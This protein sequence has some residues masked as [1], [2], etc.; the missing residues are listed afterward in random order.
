[1]KVGYNFTS[2]E[3][4]KFTEIL[5]KDGFIDYVE[6]LIDNFLSFHP[7]ELK[8]C[9]IPIA[10]HIMNSKF[11]ERSHADLCEIADKIRFVTSY[12]EILY[13]SDHILEFSDNGFNL[14]YLQEI[15]YESAIEN[16]AIIVNKIKIWNNL[17][18]KNVF[19]E[20][21]A[22]LD[23]RGLQQP[24]FIKQV[25][26]R[27]GFKVLLD[28]TNLFISTKN[29]GV[30]I[31]EW[32]DIIRDCDVFHIGSCRLS[33]ID[34]SLYIDSHDSE[35]STDFVN[36]F[37]LIKPYINFDRPCFFTY[38]R[39]FNEDIDSV[40]KDIELIKKIVA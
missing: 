22:S 13:A 32:F 33:E 30:V 4:L 20:N 9:R 28:I 40:K 38:E 26:L 8:K 37:Y 23:E 34:E 25:L 19:F 29:C 39:D 21:A 1:M 12:S 2:I 18:N 16:K 24:N 6:I 10:L 7:S 17:L 36:F 3:H 15:D 5:Y 35:I 14:P 11:L 31:D 27:N